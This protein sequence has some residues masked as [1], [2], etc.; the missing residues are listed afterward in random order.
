MSAPPPS[1][2]PPSLSINLT[3]NGVIRVYAS[4]HFKRAARIRTPPFPNSASIVYGGASDVPGEANEKVK[5][6]DVSAVPVAP[7]LMGVDNG[8]AKTQSLPGIVF[9]VASVVLS[10]IT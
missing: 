6:V 10:Y 7:Q 8:A 1:P 5:R 2:H 4:F 3:A 9:I